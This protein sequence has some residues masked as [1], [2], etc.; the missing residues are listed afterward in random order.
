MTRT[1]DLPFPQ[2]RSETMTARNFGPT[3]F[4]L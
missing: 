2:E 1:E 4:G 3:I